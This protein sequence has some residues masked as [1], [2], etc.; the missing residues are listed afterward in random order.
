MADTPKQVV[1][2][3]DK[4]T[5]GELIEFEEL[6]G[7]SAAILDSLYAGK[8]AASM[9]VVAVLAYLSE[10]R[11]NPDFTYEDALKLDVGQITYSEPQKKATRKRP[12]RA[13][14]S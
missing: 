3:F 6:T 5:M 8:G 9:K 11:V 1:L 12:T 7:E 10:K 4:P 14:S 13:S 2:K